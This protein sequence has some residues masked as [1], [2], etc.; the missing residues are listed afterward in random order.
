MSLKWLLFFSSVFYYLLLNHQYLPKLAINVQ[1]DDS[2][3][4]SNV[5]NT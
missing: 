2:D 5:F 1:T 3:F 4:D